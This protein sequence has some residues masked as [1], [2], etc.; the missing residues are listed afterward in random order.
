MPLAWWQRRE[1][2]KKKKEKNKKDNG[3]E[4]V[5]KDPDLKSDVDKKARGCTSPSFC[6]QAGDTVL[7]N[8]EI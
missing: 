4:E 2:D 6:W 1:S 7:M 5:E 8:N 3:K